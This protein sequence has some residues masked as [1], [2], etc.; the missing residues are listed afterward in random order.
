MACHGAGGR[1]CRQMQQRR[2]PSLPPAQL[3]VP[4]PQPRQLLLLLPGFLLQELQHHLAH[5]LLRLPA[6]QGHCQLLQE[7]RAYHQGWRGSVSVSPLTN[8][9]PPWSQVSPFPQCIPSALRGEEGQ[10]RGSLVF[11][12]KD[13]ECEQ[14]MR[15]LGM[16][17]RQPPPLR[18][19]SH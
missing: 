7:T 11:R 5:L 14:L 4:K 16:D 6:Q 12:D 13:K 8:T 2:P 17:P 15:E 19:S 1:V 9:N 18:P 3:Q 10:E